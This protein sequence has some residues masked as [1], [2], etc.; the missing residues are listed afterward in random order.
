LSVNTFLSH[1]DDAL[2]ASR[3]LG[4]GAQ[5]ELTTKDWNYRLSVF[6][7]QADY[8]PAI[9]F[10]RRPG[11]METSASA[12]WLP[13]PS[14][15]PIR[16]FRFSLRPSWWTDLS[17]TTISSALNIGLF[18]IAFHSGENFNIST[19]LRTDNPDSAFGIVQGVVIDAG[20]YQW[21]D[22]TASLNTSSG[23][24]LAARTSVTVG[25]WYNGTLNRFRTDLI[26]RPNERMRTEVSY[27]EEHVSL[28]QGD[29]TVRVESLAF[30]YS[31]STQLSMETLLQSD[32][33]SDTLGVQSRTRWLIAD[34]RELFFVL[35]TG[36]LE[37]DRGLIVPLG[38]D[39]TAKLV[40]AWRF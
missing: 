24:P 17:G 35:N 21:T 40:Y 19:N 39:L 32:N 20:E 12:T 2:T 6:G 13:R 36:W 4:F 18:G 3:G 31:F 25:D 37:R 22:L 1:S 9:G 33:D 15:G 38:H 23:R 10:V 27:R 14:S 26:W 30:D 16:N 28:P 5:S 11:E 29:F 34:G 7:S 8:R